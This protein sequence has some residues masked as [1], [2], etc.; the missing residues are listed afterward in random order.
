MVNTNNYAELAEKARR[1]RI[2]ALKAIHAAKSGHPGGSLS[3]ADILAT[4]YFGELNIDPKNPKMADRDKFVLS[5][6]HA[7]PALYAALGERGFYEVN[8]MMTLRQV[9]SKFQGH[10]NMNKVPG[11]EMSTGSLGQGFSAAVGMAIAGKIDK[12]PGRVYALTGDGEL[13][14]GIV[15]EAA[16][17]AAHRKLDNLVAIVDLNG[18]QI[19]GKVSDV[20]C[21]CPVDEK[22]RSFGW[23]VISVDG[24]NFEELTTAFD[25]AKKCGGVPTAI[26]AHTHKGKGVSFM[27]DN[28]GW[29]G[30]APSDEELAAAIEELGGDN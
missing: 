5:K 25:E 29:H 4:L 2:N 11:I 12:N 13:Q 20:K 22:F 28:A 24:H 6:G 18:L 15:W 14:E 21:V 17:Q 10:P 26:I 1:I 16:M 27:E 30:K 9:G 23:N 8:E 7:V 19:D 3:S